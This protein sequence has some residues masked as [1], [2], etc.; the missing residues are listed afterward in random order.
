MKSILSSFFVLLIFVQCKNT[1][2]NVSEKET[3][4]LEHLIR[5]AQNTVIKT[6]TLFL[7]HGYGSNEKDLFAL[8]QHI[9]AQWL[10][11]SVRAPNM[12]EKDKYHWYGLDRSSGSLI[13]DTNQAEEAR[14]ILLQFI[15]QMID[16]YQVDTKRI[17]IGGFSQGAIMSNSIGIT[18]PDKIKGIANFSGMILDEVKTL[19][20]EKEAYKNLKVFIAHG[21]NDPMLPFSHA[22]E[23]NAFFEGIGVN[24]SFHFDDSKHTISN[25]NF[26]AFVEWI[27]EI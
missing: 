13:H 5:T 26:T 20:A 6:P 3:F 27:K 2:K 19:K 15:D 21:Q 16:R 4:V 12:L 14:K 7:L 22:E 25:P 8:A 10:V 24:P 17:V 23:S 18:R 9:P 1:P 11:I